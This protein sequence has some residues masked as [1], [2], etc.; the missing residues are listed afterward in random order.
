[1]AVA[2]L[3]CALPWTKIVVNPM[4]ESIES[5]LSGIEVSDDRFMAW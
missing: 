3:Q 2:K 5:A 1:M 4:D